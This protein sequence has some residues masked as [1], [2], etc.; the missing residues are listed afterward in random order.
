MDDEEIVDMAVAVA[1]RMAAAAR[2]RQISVKLSTIVRYA[3]I[4]LR[5][6]TVNLRRLRGLTA[7]VR[8][9][10]RVLS[11]YVHD[12]VAEAVSRRLGAQVVWR[13][14]RRYLVIRKV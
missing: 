13:R 8:P 7:R 9:P 10:Q 1:G 3:Y 5:Y 6:R 2:S 14:G 12:A 4:A 11:R